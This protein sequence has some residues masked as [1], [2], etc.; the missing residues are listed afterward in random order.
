MATKILHESYDHPNALIRREESQLAAA[1]AANTTVAIFRR[2]QASRLKAIH[3][4]VVVAGTGT[5]A[6]YRI[7]VGTSSVGALTFGTSAIGSVG[8]LVLDT[9]LTANQVVSAE[10]VADATIVAALNF[11]YEIPPSPTVTQ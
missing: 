2:Y 5:T 6:G 1:A 4:Q 9:A 8:S 3:G 7:K 11:E 10:N